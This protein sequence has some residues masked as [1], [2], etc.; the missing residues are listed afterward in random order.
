VKVH[1]D[2]QIFSDQTRGGISRYFIELMNAFGADPSLGV[3]LTS[4]RFWSINRLLLEYG[5]ARRVPT[6]LGRIPPVL[7]F[8][9]RFQQRSQ[10]AVIVHHT[11]YHGE[12][13]KRFKNARV[14]V[15]TIYDMIPERFPEI[16]PGG[17]PHKDKKDFVESAD[18]ILCISEATKQ[19]VIEIYGQPAAPIEVTPLAASSLFRPGAERL[20]VLP[21]RY[22]LFVG[23]RSHYKDF[24]VLARAFARAGLQDVRLVAVGGGPWTQSERSLLLELGISARALQLELD[25]LGLASAYANALCFVFPSRYEGFGLPTLEAMASGCATILAA[26]SSH[27]EVGGDAAVY[28]VPGDETDLARALARVVGDTDA[29]REMRARGF[30]RAAAFDWRGTARMTAGAYLEALN[31]G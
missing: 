30:R 9:N 26:S 27:P 21:D 4:P 29:H 17:N 11:Y 3:E 31:R 20:G 14:R 22:V 2:D 5:G 18:L 19:D 25:D 16:Y 10:S 28:F 24:A 7:R 12:Y 1:F 15:V 6:S 8:A 23:K 13:L